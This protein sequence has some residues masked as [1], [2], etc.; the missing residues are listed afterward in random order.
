MYICNVIHECKLILNACTCVGARTRSRAC[1][2]TTTVFDFFALSSPE[3]QTCFIV[4]IFSELTI[5]SPTLE[6]TA[7]EDMLIPA[8]CVKTIHRLIVAFSKQM[9]IPGTNDF[10]VWRCVLRF[11]LN[12][13]NEIVSIDNCVPLIHNDDW[14]TRACGHVTQTQML[15]R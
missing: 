11:F 3:R 5:P 14:C 12:E 7:V 13:R 6:P 10:I 8:L 1:V 4:V 2:Q 9:M 15:P